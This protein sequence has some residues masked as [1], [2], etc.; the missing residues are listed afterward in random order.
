MYVCY[1]YRHTYVCVADL[2]LF[3]PFP[4]LFHFLLC[5][6]KVLKLNFPIKI[7]VGFV[8]AA[9]AVAATPS[10]IQW[11]MPICKVRIELTNFGALLLMRGRFIF[12]MVNLPANRWIMAL[13]QTD[14]NKN[15]DG[16]YVHVCSLFLAFNKT[17]SNCFILLA[18]QRLFILTNFHWKFNCVR[19]F[20][21]Q[22]F[23]ILPICFLF[24]PIFCVWA[25][26]FERSTLTETT[27]CLRRSVLCS[28]PKTRLSASRQF[29]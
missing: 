24:F 23:S 12:K 21:S 28:M 11:E 4:F 8:I 6:C 25:V 2:L 1:A 14:Q 5:K 9:A 26:A 16:Q 3:T 18:F 27:F 7:V 20:C 29:V 17:R 15:W 13:S 19:V 10:S 22:C